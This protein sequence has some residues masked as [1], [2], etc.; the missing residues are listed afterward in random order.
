MKEIIDPT[1]IVRMFEI[2]FNKSCDAA[3]KYSSVVDQTFLR[4]VSEGIHLREDGHYEIH[5]LKLSV[6]V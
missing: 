3:A 2:D 6:P 1:A 5:I 4:K